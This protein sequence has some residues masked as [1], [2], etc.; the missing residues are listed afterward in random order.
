MKRFFSLVF[1]VLALAIAGCG[2]DAPTPS[3][4][5]TDNPTDEP[6]DEPV[7]KPGKPEQSM[8]V[9]SIAWLDVAGAGVAEIAYP[10]N[11]LSGAIITVDYVIT[12][13]EAAVDVVT[14]HRDML[15]VEATNAGESI[16]LAITG[17]KAGDNQ[18]EIRIT[19]AARELTDYIYNDTLDA[20]LTVCVED[21]EN[22]VRAEAIALTATKL[23]VTLIAPERVDKGSEIR[24]EVKAGD[25]SLTQGYTI[26]DAA[27]G[28][29]V[30]NPYT[31]AQ[32]G[33]Y[34]FYAQYFATR[35]SEVGIEVV[36]NDITDEEYDPAPESIDF[37]HRVLLIEHTGTAC[38]NCPTM[39]SAIKELD[40]SSYAGRYNLVEAHYGAF[41]GGDPAAS[42]AAT[43]L[44]LV[45]G[46]SSFPAATFNFYYSKV[47]SATL[48]NL[49]THLAYTW[50][51][52]AK[53]S[54]AVKAVDKDATID[55]QVVVKSGATQQYRV[56]CWLLEDNI[57]GLQSG[58]SEL[59]HNYHNHVLRAMMG[60]TEA[61]LDITGDALGE[62]E[63]GKSANF[64]VSIPVDAAWNNEE[65]SVLVLITAP[66][67]DH[68]NKFEVVNTVYCPVGETKPIEYN[69]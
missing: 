57:Y 52:Q 60:A 17:C 37:K 69:E 29:A 39:K 6:S 68:D 24:F 26:I 19:I 62:I 21:E 1:M 38:V 18:G 36:S 65:L 32:A 28:D 25:E 11:T 23:P 13:A 30:S 58:A 55:V 2:D 7:D 59:W 35:S 3:N 49:K 54:A 45:R 31:V 8:G 40:E 9:E 56:A 53:A 42:A 41:A 66:D 46:V 48:A 27:S 34:T 12:P 51:K 64:E 44:G 15:Y 33:S 43:L 61:T 10:D 14:Y 47:G 5:P 67:A 20:E 4:N 63:E 22:T 50:K 16:D